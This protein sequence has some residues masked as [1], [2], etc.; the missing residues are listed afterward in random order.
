MTE[1]APTSFSL[2]RRSAVA[3]IGAALLLP[4]AACAGGNDSQGKSPASTSP[5]PEPPAGAQ[6]PLGSLAGAP[7]LSDEQYET[8]V[9]GVSAWVTR[10]WPLM[11]QVWPGVDYTRHRIVAM[12][13]DEQFKAIRAWAISVDGQRELKADEYASIEVPTSYGKITFEDQPSITLNLGQAAT[14][15]VSNR[16]GGGAAAGMNSTPSVTAT[17][18]SEPVADLK[19]PA[20]YAFALMTHELVHF[21]YQGEINVTASSSRDTPYPYQARPRTLRR[22]ML[23]RLRQAAMDADKR[24]EHLGHARYWMDTWKSEFAGEAEDIH[25]YDIAE[26]IARY[27]EYMALS[28]QEN[29]SPEQLQTRQAA[30]LKE[31]PLDV[32]VDVESYVFG[33]ITGVLLDAIKP[34]WK[35]GFYASGKTL[36]EMLLE[37]VAPVPEEVDPEVGGQVDEAIKEA[38]QYVAPDIKKIDDAEADTSV[39]YLHLPKLDEIGYASSFVYKDKVVLTT[40]IMVLNGDGQNLQVLGVPTFT[41]ADRESLYIPLINAPHSY[42]D[43]VLT[44]TGDEITG[45]IKAEKTTENGREVFVAK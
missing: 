23:H 29:Q 18:A 8:V 2:T 40:T 21:Y 42:A 1:S 13:V 37:D 34:D 27:V 10:V 26:G 11:G 3:A 39:A 7:S 20:T 16:E 36:T 30:L 28:I 14:V 43:G 41:G 22:M 44:V 6:D 17:G 25:H 45:T 9:E 32:S 35:N 19:D 31:E 24:S 38:D 5:T 4:L 12:Q 15:G 33:F